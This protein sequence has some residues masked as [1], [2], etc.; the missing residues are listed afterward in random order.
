M[1]DWL[2]QMFQDSV[3]VPWNTLIVRLT[4]ALVLG[5]VITLVYRS[6]RHPAASAGTFP[7]TLVLLCVLIATVTQVIGDNVALAFSLVGALSIVRFRTVVRD[8]KD[9]AFVLFAVVIGMAVGAGQPTVALCGMAVASVA[10]ALFRDPA[11]GSPSFAREAV[12][13]V[14][15]V[16]STALESLVVDTLSKYATEIEPHGVSTVRHGTAMELVYHAQLLPQT[17]PTDLVAEL[18]RL[19]GVQGVELQTHRPEA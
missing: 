7:A 8:T 12:L 18:N 6:T 4:A 15:L 2:N 14:R 9:T 13:T 10:A 16:W 11:Q 17:K 5:M 1:P 19:E 3:S